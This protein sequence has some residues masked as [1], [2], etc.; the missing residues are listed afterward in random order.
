[1]WC[2]HVPA[3]IHIDTSCYHM[4]V[5]RNML[6]H[7]ETHYPSE[8]V[9]NK[10]NGLF[11]DLSDIFGRTS[12][13]IYHPGLVFWAVDVWLDP[14]PTSIQRHTKPNTACLPG[15][16][17]K[18]WVIDLTNVL[19]M[20]VG[21]LQKNNAELQKIKITENYVMLYSGNLWNI[22]CGYLGMG[23]QGMSVTPY[24]KIFKAPILAVLSIDHT[25]CLSA[26]LIS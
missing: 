18:S 3:I 14:N 13:I 8:H 24:L 16:A 1:M 21:S 22:I 26:H 7:V 23:Q 10:Q 4:A 20:Q 11:G 19:P 25:G 15:A 2:Q 12:T 9:K 5:G 17:W 6:K